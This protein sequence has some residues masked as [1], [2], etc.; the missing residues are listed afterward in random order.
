MVVVLKL[1][2]IVLLLLPN[3]YTLPHNLGSEVENIILILKATIKA[4][5]KVGLSENVKT[6]QKI[7]VPAGR[8]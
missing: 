7:S 2:I 1:H 3:F 6:S 4:N 8:R 5:R